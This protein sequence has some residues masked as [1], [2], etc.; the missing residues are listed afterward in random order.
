[1]LTFFVDTLRLYSLTK[2]VLCS[3]LRVTQTCKK[4]LKTHVWESQ[5]YIG[6]TLAGNLF[7]SVAILFVGALPAQALRMFK[8]INCCTIGRKTYF[9]HQRFFLQPAIHFI[10][11]SQQQGFISNFRRERKAT[12]TKN[13]S[14][15]EK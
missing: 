9:R 15:E 4:C 11:T 7:V 8:V 14:T 12:T 6:K 3:F 13:A 5:P 1:M 10:W 2:A